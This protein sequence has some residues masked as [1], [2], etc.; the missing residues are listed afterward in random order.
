MRENKHLTDSQVKK[1]TKALTSE[2]D[3]ILINLDL[4]AGQYKMQN[5]ERKDS[6]DEA[7]ENILMSYR[8]RLTNRGNL[9][10]KKIIKSLRKIEIGEYGVCDECGAGIPMERM[11]ARL[12]SDMCIVCKEESEM[13]EH[14]SIFGK[15]SKSLGRTL[16]VN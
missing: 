8:T 5:S 11:M 1:L 12:T 10:L 6:V 3:K 4:K 13:E 2:K 16:R 7:N 15:K 9:Y 14:H